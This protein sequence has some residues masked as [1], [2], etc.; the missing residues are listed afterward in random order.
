MRVN[1]LRYARLPSPPLNHLKS[2][3]TAVEEYTHIEYILC[4]GLFNVLSSKGDTD[5]YTS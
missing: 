1:I 3:Q 4:N 5:V 2:I